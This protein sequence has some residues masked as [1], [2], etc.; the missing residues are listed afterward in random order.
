MEPFNPIFLI[1]FSKSNRMKIK[2]VAG[3]CYAPAA[4]RHSFW[5][6]ELENGLLM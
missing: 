2:F 4:G 1:E 6:T 5:L 3:S